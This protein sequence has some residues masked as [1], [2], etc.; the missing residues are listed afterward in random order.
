MNSN[1]NNSNKNISINNVSGVPN[2]KYQVNKTGKIT[3][4]SLLNNKRLS[5]KIKK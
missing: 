4:S 2:G 5:T 3:T 1:I